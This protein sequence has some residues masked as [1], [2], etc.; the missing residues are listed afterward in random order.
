MR[1][2]GSKAL[3]LDNILYVINQHTKNVL[4]IFVQQ[5][6]FHSYMINERLPLLKKANPFFNVKE[7]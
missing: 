1:Y 7:G 3:M 5:S 2:I 6:Q 4:S